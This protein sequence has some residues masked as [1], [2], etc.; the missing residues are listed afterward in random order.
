MTYRN[1][2]PSV[3]FFHRE[4]AHTTL[5]NWQRS[6]ETAFVVSEAIVP[7]PIDARTSIYMS[8]RVRSMLTDQSEKAKRMVLNG[9][10]DL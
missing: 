4:K 3:L 7:D 8:H 10:A 9:I 2:Y 6:S 1:I 5:E